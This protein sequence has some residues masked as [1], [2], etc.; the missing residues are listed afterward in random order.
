MKLVLD[1]SAAIAAVGPANP[2]VE[3]MIGDAEIVI[4]PTLFIAEVANGVWKYVIQGDLAVDTGVRFLR[5]ASDLV[6]EFR[7]VADLT[8]EV[9]RKAAA[10]RHPVYDVYYAVLARREKAAVLTIDRR[11]KQLCAE[12]GVPLADA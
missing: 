3:T 9:L 1:A 2:R 11:L 12:M 8:E 5:A 7:D 10:H 6:N 4:A